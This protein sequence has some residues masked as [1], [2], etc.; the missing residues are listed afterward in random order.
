MMNRLLNFI[1]YHNA[2]PVALGILV[3]GA[4]ATFAATNPQAVYSQTQTPVSV[5]NTYIANKELSSYTPRAQIMQITEDADNYYVEYD[6]LTIDVQEYVWR[7][8]S[9]RNTLTVAKSALSGG[10]LAAYVT[11]QLKQNLDHEIDR[12]QESQT[13]ARRD[14]SQK[15]VATTYG[16][17][18]G[19]F[20]DETTETLPGYVPP[21][22]PVVLSAPQGNVSVQ[23]GTA[24]TSSES[25]LTREQVVQIIEQRVNELLT[26]QQTPATTPAD[27]T[28]P[29][30]ATEEPPPPP[31]AQETPP[32]PTPEPAP[33]EP[34]PEPSPTPEPAPEPTPAP[35]E[36]PAAQ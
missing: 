20:L 12:L 9:K 4:G 32:A 2:V 36:A 25:A 28:P 27:T 31:P 18:I 6:F 14:V 21:Q 3:L 19:A 13:I 30:P 34:T 16:G 1:Q 5:D 8:V 35:A 23:A 22:E 33:S 11:E 15:T 17:L 7:D 24:N 29:P 10:N 26:Q